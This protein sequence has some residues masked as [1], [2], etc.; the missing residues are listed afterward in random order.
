[1]CVREPP[2][3]YSALSV[4]TGWLALA[5]GLLHKVLRKDLLGPHLM[6]A[7]VVGLVLGAWFTPFPKK[8]ARGAK[9][10]FKTNAR[11]GIWYPLA[12]RGFAQA[13]EITAFWGKIVRKTLWVRNKGDCE[14]SVRDQKMV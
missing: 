8:A 1:M 12:E 11:Q 2:L 10:T 5:G 14:V 9:K 6:G 7:S 4:L 13:P 3:S